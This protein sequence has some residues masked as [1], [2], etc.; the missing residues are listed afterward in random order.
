MTV[1]PV[2]TLPPD[3]C[4]TDWLR[5]PMPEPG[6]SWVGPLP[7]DLGEPAWPPPGLMDET[8]PGPLLA[9]LIGEM[10][11]SSASA[12][13]LVELAS[14][15]ARLASWA[16]S[17]EIDATVELSECV[18]QMRGVVDEP[19][20]VGAD[21]RGVPP[22][23]MVTAE[24]GA[25]LNLS[26]WAAENRVQLALSLRRLPTTRAMLAAG[27]IDLVKSR[28][29]AEAV[30]TLDDGQAEAVEQ[31]VLAKADSRTV[32]ELRAAL[33]RA[34]ISVD[35]TAAQARHERAVAERGARREP[36]PDG[37]ARMEYVDA[38][39]HVESLYQ[40]L[41]GKALA[42]RGPG[43]P[44]S[45][46]QCRADVLADLGRDGLLHD[47]LPTRQGRRPNIGVAVALTTLLGLDDE[48]GELVGVG[49]IT[50]DV[51]R[52]IAADGTW[53]RMLVDPRTGRF[54]EMSVDTYDAPQDLRDHVIARDRTCRG[55][56]CRLDARRCDLDHRTPHPVGPTSAANL[57][58]AC[59][60]WHMVKTFTDTT[61][62][63]DGSGGLHITLPS[64]RRYHR[65]AEVFL[66]H[67]GLVP[68][69]APPP[70]PDIPPF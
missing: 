3:P 7:P 16:A 20:S 68:R 63:P 60:S 58:A 33:R 1:I 27:R 56:G 50:A 59:R 18:R 46:D 66:E 26:P 32:G 30:L 48:P 53:R 54:D 51:A 2:D 47:R 29:I 22:G 64:G 13:Q 65:P 25:A 61:V 31:R 49:P 62:E 19:R 10:D 23:L 41:T 70:E 34:V 12:A 43:D 39:E 14:A 55:L 15:A 40:W 24:I 45:L 36:L 21:P 57:D 35:P 44:R 11:V 17:R 37:M 38:A 28:A 5:A 4:G 6:P 42:A 8:L 9:T 67:P 52:R 69:P